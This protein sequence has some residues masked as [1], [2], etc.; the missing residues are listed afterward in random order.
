MGAQTELHDGKDVRDLQALADQALD[1]RIRHK[2]KPLSRAGQLHLIDLLSRYS[3]FGLAIF[4]GVTILIALTISREAPLRTAVWAALVFGS[5]FLCARYRKDFRIGEKIASRPF[6]WRAN[7]TA[8]LC[9]LSAAFGS[10]AIL[11]FSEAVTSP[12]E[13]FALLLLAAFGASM[14]SIAHPVSAAAA[15]IPAAGFIL[16]GALKSIGPSTGYF[17]V[18]GVTALAAAAVT[19]MVWRL[20]TLTARRFPRTGFIRSEIGYNLEI[21]TQQAEHRAQLGAA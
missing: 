4:A 14:L 15:F 1:G 9:V 13:F 3:G 11:L 16:L 7:Y 19:A 8:A 2:R 6:R 12:L 10:A 17:V 20:H 18:V 5:L 21:K